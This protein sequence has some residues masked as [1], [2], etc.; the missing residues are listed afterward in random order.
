MEMSNFPRQSVRGSI[1]RPRRPFA[2][3]SSRAVTTIQPRCTR[4]EPAERFPNPMTPLTWDFLGAVFRRSL[5]L[6]AVM[7]VRWVTSRLHD[8]D[9]VIVEGTQG[10]V[11]ITSA[12]NDSTM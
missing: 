11:T 6:P 3:N 10:V 4:D 2:A 5:D 1:D 7:S 12:E 8:C 9:I